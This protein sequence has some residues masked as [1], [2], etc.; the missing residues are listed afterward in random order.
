[1]AKQ[2]FEISDAK[3]NR[4]DEFYT[5]LIDIEK[6]VFSYVTCNQNPFRGKIIFL[7]ADNPRFSNF[8]NFFT[9]QFEKLQIKKIITT[10]YNPSGAGSLCIISGVDDIS[11]HCLNGNGDFRSEEVSKFLNEC[12]IIITNP[13]FSLFREF[14]DWVIKSNKKF[15]LL[16][17]IN[18]IAYK[19]IFDLIKDNKLWLGQSIS[20]GG[21]E[22]EIPKDRIEMNKFSGTVRGGKFFQQ[23]IV[24]WFTNLDYQ[25]RHIQLNLMT[26]DEI[27][28]RILGRPFE[29]YDDYDAI[30]VS[31]TKNIPSDYEGTM[32]VPISF[33]DKY[34]SG[35][36]DLLGCHEPCINIDLLK[37]RTDF[38]EFKSR[39]VIHR[40]LIC[41]KVYHRI[42]IRHKRVHEDGH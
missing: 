17:N 38:K 19:K 42:F 22:F 37:K 11:Y 26:K 36:F 21:R 10:C 31:K 1:M 5:Q 4:N 18:A 3:K 2:V 34:C 14:V 39:Q 25:K 13:P 30:E 9:T 15:L 16:G 24:R 40:G 41:Q 7:P 35:Q 12:D 29:K 28:G 27:E 6:E 32:G 8:V 20:S 23:I 33:L